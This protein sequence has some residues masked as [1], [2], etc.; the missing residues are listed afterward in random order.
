[1]LARGAAAEIVAGDQDLG[2]PVGR[3]VE[4]EIG[5]LSSVVAVALLGKQT[6]AETG[7]LDGFQVLLGDDHVGVDVDHPQRRRNAFKR[8]EL[9]HSGCRSCPFAFS[10]SIYRECGP[11]GRPTRHQSATR[12]IAS[13]PSS[14]R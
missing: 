5:V 10:G 3:L 8:G 9:V 14:E 7:A 4:H 12:S 11:Y 2:V 1:M 13:M 6:L